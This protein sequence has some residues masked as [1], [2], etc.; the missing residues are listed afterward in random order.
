[1]SIKINQ[2]LFNGKCVDVVI[3]NDMISRI[4]P[5][6]EGSFDCVIDGKNGAE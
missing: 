4:A 6:I 3:E 1:M 2:V 5:V